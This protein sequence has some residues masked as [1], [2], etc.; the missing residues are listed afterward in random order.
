MTTVMT[1]DAGPGIALIDVILADDGLL[2]DF[3]FTLDPGHSAL[4]GL[5]ATCQKAALNEKHHA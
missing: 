2:N 1:P 4:L 5:C 3:G